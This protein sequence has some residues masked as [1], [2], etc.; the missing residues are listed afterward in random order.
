M[1]G[2][3]RGARLQRVSRRQR[4]RVVTPRIP[5]TADSCS[6]VQSTDYRR[7][8]GG[9]VRDDAPRPTRG[10]PSQ[11]VDV[12]FAHDTPGLHARAGSPPTM[13]VASSLLRRFRAVVAVL[14]KAVADANGN[15]AMADERS[16]G[17]N[18]LADC[19][20]E[21]LANGQGPWQSLVARSLEQRM[22]RCRSRGGSRQA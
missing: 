22:W 17:H 1:A 12:R 20:T 7:S 9:L 2:A 14:G 3:R 18:R 5:S 8:Q 10:P 11:H 13:D 16:V 6:T 4:S 15:I 21:T 19:S